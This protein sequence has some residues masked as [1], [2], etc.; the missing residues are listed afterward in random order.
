MWVSESTVLVNYPGVSDSKDVMK[1][2]LTVRT[3]STIYSCFTLS[4]TTKHKRFEESRF[5]EVR[6]MFVIL[7]NNRGE[8]YF[9][10]L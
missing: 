1:H 2:G 6:V 7:L 10:S 4:L 9:S 3:L 8:M 5:R